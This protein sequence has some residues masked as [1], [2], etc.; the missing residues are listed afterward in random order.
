MLAVD[1]GRSGRGIAQ[2]LV[3]VCLENGRRKGYGRAVTEA[4]GKISQQVFRKNAF[5]ECF[6]VFYQQ[7]LYEG[8]PV[9][10]SITE[11]ERAILMERE[12]DG[13]S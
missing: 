5:A 8:A 10:A 2:E 6:S 3:R 1:A 4:T 13:E 11:H 7:F 12:F 9:F